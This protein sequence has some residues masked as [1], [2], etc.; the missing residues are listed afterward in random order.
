MSFPVWFWPLPSDAASGHIGPLLAARGLALAPYGSGFAIADWTQPSVWPVNPVT[1]SF[2]KQIYLAGGPPGLA[3]IAPAPSGGIWALGVTGALWF[4]ANGVGVPVVN[5]ASGS[6]RVFTGLG[7]TSGSAFP[8]AVASDG[9]VWSAANTEIGSFNTP[10]WF[11]ALSGSTLYSLL[12]SG[13]VQSIGQMTL[14]G[15][16]GSIALPGILS[17][18]AALTVQASGALFAAGWQ[19]AA[20]LS[21]FN[22]VQLN[23]ANNT[24]VAGVA[25]G[26]A[27]IL[28]APAAN[29]N[30]WA[31]STSL[32]GLANLSKLAWMPDG[33]QL[34]VTASGSNS[35]Q[36][37]DFTG[38]ALTLSQTLTVSGAN[39]VGVTTDSAYALL[40]QADHNAAITLVN[41]SG[42]WSI[43]TSVTGLTGIMDVAVRGTTQG[44]AAFASGIA[45]LAL[46]GGA[47]SVT[48]TVSTGALGFTPS[49]LTY[50]SFG[51]LYAAGLS[52]IAMLSGATLL[53]TGTY[54]GQ[55]PTGLAVQAG[56]ILVPTPADGIVRVFAQSAATTISQQASAPLTVS[57][58]TSVFAGCAYSTVF[59]AASGAT[60]M[61][62]FNAAPFV[63]NPVYAGTVGFWNGSWTTH[64]LGVDYL[65]FAA[66]LDA[67]GTGWVA[68]SNNYLFSISGNGTLLT[69]ALVSPYPGQFTG[70]PLTLS[71]LFASGGHIWG[72]T[73]LPGV[74]GEL[75]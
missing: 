23:P 50:D 6:N 14:T 63:L 52:G 16:T 59:M 55:P 65:P 41:S 53:A 46:I 34:L 30:R 47:W 37:L 32:S 1:N 26:L 40:A 21:G 5:I 73:A 15:V 22:A 51:T 13:S 74:A 4:A 9:T 72:A 8:L 36:I 28:S 43:G 64:S 66:T 42:T 33:V 20:P 71:A 56:R 48:S 31:F 12:T 54:S 61:F 70:V 2:G 18:V 11:A 3:G 35:L 68:T 60:E 75:V 24:L 62:Q 39:S 57:G 58:S 69:S 19:N 17:T 45:L 38:G 25:S 67:S 10:T 29:S 44:A 49:Y 27:T 7:S